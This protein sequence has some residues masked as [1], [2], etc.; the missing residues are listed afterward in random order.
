MPRDGVTAGGL[1]VRDATQHDQAAVLALNNASTPHVNA[2]EPE[3]FAW[4][5][6]SADYYRV[7]VR[8]GALEGF[9]IALR[10]GTDYWSDNYAWFGAH[11]DRFLYLDRVVVAPSA[12][13]GG[14]G[15]ALYADLVAF[16]SGR[17]PRITLEVNIEPPNAGSVAFHETLGFQRVG[18]REYVGGAVAMFVLPLRAPLGRRPFP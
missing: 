5:V 16:A 11:F 15:R 18:T 17:W 6:A 10:N 13:R 9:V 8:D 3:Q 4:I 1:V 14:V 7:A 12:R 2:L